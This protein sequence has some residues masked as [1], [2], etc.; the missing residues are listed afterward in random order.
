MVSEG[1]FFLIWRGHFINSPSPVNVCISTSIILFLPPPLC[2]SLSD[3]NVL[4]IDECASS[5]C[6]NGATCT[7]AVNSYTCRCVA[8]YTGKLCETGESLT[9][10]QECSHSVGTV[11]GSTVVYH[12]ILWYTSRICSLPLFLS[13]QP[14]PVSHSPMSSLVVIAPR[15]VRY[16]RVSTM[17][18]A[19]WRVISVTC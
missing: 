3:V 1:E 9:V 4:E 18:L 10:T 14:S 19:K 8:G 16:R 11:S 13:K 17:T 2:Q 12:D 5:P 6:E 7:D 15:P